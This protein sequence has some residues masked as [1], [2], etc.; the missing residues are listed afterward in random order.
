M[1]SPNAALNVDGDEDESAT[2]SDSTA[3]KTDSD[4]DSETETD[5]EI[6]NRYDTGPFRE[7]E[8]VLAYHK[9]CIYV[10]KVLQFE[11]RS[12][13]WHY[14]VH[15]LGWNKSWDE[16]VGVDRL[17]K[18]T[19]E[20]RMKQEALNKKLEEQKKAELQTSKRGT[21]G[22]RG[23]KRKKDSSSK[24]KSA[25]PP[26]KLVNIQIP[27]TLKKQLIDDCEFIT[28]LGKLV[29][30]PR[31]PNVEDILKLYLDYRCKKDGT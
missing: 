31:T 2:V 25:V 22:G 8:K 27:L 28:H 6:R 24:E 12:N 15:Y 3:T 17:L 5:E 19:D 9:Q 11:K 29:K 23:K 13:G 18:Y 10:A 14:Y 20:N 21:A 4:S 7:G 26:E 16:W 30:L 1:G